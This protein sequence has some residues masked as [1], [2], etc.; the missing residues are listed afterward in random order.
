[1]IDV[2]KRIEVVVIS[3]EIATLLLLDEFM[4]FQFCV[5]FMFRKPILI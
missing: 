2:V 1:M 3:D 4:T 5:R